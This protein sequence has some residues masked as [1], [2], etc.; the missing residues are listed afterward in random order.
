MLTSETFQADLISMN[1]YSKINVYNHV[2][3]LTGFIWPIQSEGLLSL[4][5]RVHALLGTRIKNQQFFTVRNRA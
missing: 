3:G 1:K 4:P 2:K 5:C